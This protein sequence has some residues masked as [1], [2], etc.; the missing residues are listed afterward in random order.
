MTDEHLGWARNWVDAPTQV[1]GFSAS[2]LNAAIRDG[3]MIAGNGVVVLVEIGAAGVR[4][5]GLGFAPYHPVAGDE[6]WITVKAPPW[7]PVTEVRLV[8]SRGTTVIADQL[9]QPADPF[10]TDGI[11]R[12]SGTLDLS[13]VVDRD[14]FVIVEAGLAY[15]LS[16]DLNDDGVPDTT[17][18]NQD[19][20]VDQDDVDP[21][22]DVGPFTAPPDPSDAADPRY[23]FTRIIPG[24][25]PE[26]FANPLLLDKDGDGVWTP[27][28]LR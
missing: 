8:T 24:G 21:D 14:D 2:T 3:H 4:K 17:D 18:N 5:R 15:P 9:P 12:Y 28:G 27:P 19:C 13:A 26:G 25:W 10:G 20:V 7:V 23:I 1:I 22:E 11:V 6:L 16:A